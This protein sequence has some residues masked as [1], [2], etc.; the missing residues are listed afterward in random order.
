MRAPL[1]ARYLGF[2]RRV[3][4]S[5]APV[6]GLE[7][8]SPAVPRGFAGCQPASSH[9]LQDYFIPRPRGVSFLTHMPK[10]LDKGL[11]FVAPMAGG[12]LVLGAVRRARLRRFST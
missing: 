7:G 9:L 4:R 6:F 12:S 11:F 1:G 3:A 10:G 5:A 2:G 8:G